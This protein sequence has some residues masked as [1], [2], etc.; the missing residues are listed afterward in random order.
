LAAYNTLVK[1]QVFPRSCLMQYG[2][3]KM[4]ESAP[5][6]ESVA[7]FQQSEAIDHFRIGP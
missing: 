4:K 3:G 1:Q 5:T 7:L 6:E 2:S